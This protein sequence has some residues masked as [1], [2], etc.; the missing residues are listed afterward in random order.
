MIG[1]VISTCEYLYQTKLKL[2]L[3]LFFKF[4]IPKLP[5]VAPASQFEVGGVEKRGGGKR[6]F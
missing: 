2:E 3:D 1:G 5:V 6:K 4:V